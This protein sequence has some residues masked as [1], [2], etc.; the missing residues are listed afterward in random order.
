MTVESTEE[1]E[2]ESGFVC[3]L[4]GGLSPFPLLRCCRGLPVPVCPLLLLL[5]LPLPLPLPLLLM[6]MLLLM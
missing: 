1:R 6:L 2:R 3:R 5:E 4:E